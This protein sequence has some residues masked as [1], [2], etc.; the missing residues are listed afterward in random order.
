MCVISGFTSFVKGDTPWNF[1]FSILKPF[2]GVPLAP[3]ILTKSHFWPLCLSLVLGRRRLKVSH[4][5]S[6][7]AVQI[8]CRLWCHHLHYSPVLLWTTMFP[9]VWQLQ[10]LSLSVGWTTELCVTLRLTLKPMELLSIDAATTAELRH[11]PRRPILYC[12]WKCS[13]SHSKM[14]EALYSGVVI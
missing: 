1:T 3:S 2:F 8:C 14:R 13:E 7:Q 9:W 11:P 4:W 12:S 5:F 6:K 10:Q